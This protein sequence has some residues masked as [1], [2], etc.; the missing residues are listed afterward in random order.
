MTFINT[1]D[2]VSQTTS[3]GISI[4][5]LTGKP[6]ALFAAFDQFP[7]AKGAAVHISQFAPALFNQFGSGVLYTLGGNG[8]PSYQKEQNVEIVR[9][10]EQIS[11]FLERT[12]VFGHALEGILSQV[13][14]TLQI[15]HFRDPWSGI[16]IIEHQDLHC[17][18]VYEVNGLPSIELLYRYPNIGESLLLKIR[19]LED[20]CLERS[21]AIIT[22]SN[23]I[24]EHL[25]TRGVKDEKITV[26]QNGADIPPVSPRPETTPPNYILY[27]GAL[28]PWQGIDILLK[29]F[30]LLEDLSDLQLVIITG[31]SSRMCKPFYKY[32][33]KQGFDDRVIWHH[34]IPHSE[35]ANWIAHAR[36]SVAPL[37]ECSRNLVQ[38]CCPL[39]IIESM[40]GATPVIASDLPCIREI[41]TDGED[42]YLVRPDRPEALARGIR[43]LLEY[44]DAVSTM[45][46]KAQE[47]IRQK[48]TWQHSLEKLSNV[49]NKLCADTCR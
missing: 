36:L 42:G 1:P 41:I 3:H 31:S 47:K 45:G 44:P 40:A 21:D 16:P 6:S 7:S 2:T 10:T 46:E 30:E 23:V 37:T 5:C 28:Q 29:A 48:L 4:P 17:K 38:G 20:R 33:Q 49:Y 15:A 26:I 43:V 22:V 32:I 13:Q 24:R 8:L 19:V 11:N 25:L 18:R 39:K 35:L 14:E 34:R 9:F 27:F 12:V